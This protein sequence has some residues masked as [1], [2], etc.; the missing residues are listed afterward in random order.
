MTLVTDSDGAGWM[1]IVE[2]KQTNSMVNKTQWDS[3]I[4]KW[5]NVSWILKSIVFRILMQQTVSLRFVAL[6]IVTI[7]S[8]IG[9]P[10]LSRS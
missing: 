1:T 2:Q 9:A 4:L 6:A 8:A 5:G 10:Q 3:N 7:S